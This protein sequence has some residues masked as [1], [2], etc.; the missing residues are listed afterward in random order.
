MTSPCDRPEFSHIIAV[1]DLPAAGR[2]FRCAATGAERSAL[3][4]RFALSAVR[5]LSVAG[6]LMPVAGGRRVRLTARLRADVTQTCVVTL[7][8]VDSVIEVPVERLYAGDVLDEWGGA[9][10]ADIE[11][12][13]SHDREPAPEP[14]P[15][16]GIDIGEVAAEEMGLA[17]DPF[18]RRAGAVFDAGQHASGVDAKAAGPLAALGRRLASRNDGN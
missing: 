10:D 16:H 5:H 12:V 7:D 8:P 3:A 17:L 14:L 9:A 4:Q 2:P 18:P 15:A 6:I 13:L 1:G 11:I